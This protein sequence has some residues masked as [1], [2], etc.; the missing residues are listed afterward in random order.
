MIKVAIV[1]ATGYTGVE[2]I[3]Y[4]KLHPEVELFSLVSHSNNGKKLSQVYPQF[5]GDLVLEEFDSDKLSNC[6]IVFTALPH[7]VSQKRVAELYEKGVRVIDLSGDFRYQETGI[8]EKWYQEKHH[9]PELM[10][11][12]VY[13]LV[14]LN[15]ERIKK[16]SL[17]ANP[18][19]YPTASIL[20]IFPLLNKGLVEKNSIIIDAKS[21]VSGAGKTPGKG[22]HF[23]EV[24]ESIKAYGIGTHRHT[25]EI[26][27]N[28][29]YLSGKKEVQV[30][31]TPHLVPMKR[32]ILA[33]IYADLEQKV[34]LNE[35]YAAYE[36]CY[37]DSYFI[38]IFKNKSP[39]TKHVYGS[40]Y[41]QIGV[42]LDVRNSRA[43]IV[44]AIDNLGKG[45]ASQAIQNMNVLFSLPEE[46][47]LESSPVF[48]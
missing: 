13:G 17:V 3:R 16:A 38:N 10:S 29:G 24:D 43:I 1:G 9:F 25:S 32:G 7:G 45:A 21:G 14:E 46:T 18:G 8:Y 42:N 11:E 20:G 34:A 2:L 26:E 35:L 39:E 31:F 22:T 15:R 44:S 33:T 27:A 6:D 30:S 28:L 12:S 48:P 4:L 19:C 37:G 40:N 47:G 23:C 5:A 36:E 41:C